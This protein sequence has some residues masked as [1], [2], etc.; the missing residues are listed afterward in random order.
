[1]AL[2]P[3]L[4]E[5][6]LSEEERVNHL[7][8]F[9]QGI[10]EQLESSADQK[11]SVTGAA[12]EHGR[13]RY[14]QGYSIPLM[15]EDARLLQDAIYELIQD[16]LLTLD[17]SRLISDLRR[18]DDTVDIELKEAIQAYIAEEKSA[19]TGKKKREPSRVAKAAARKK[20]AG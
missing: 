8:A 7:P 4:A 2:H 15:I 16:N 3:E 18:M 11:A 6:K 13:M 9:L 5:L 20:V 1:M 17:L 10:A 14:R 19:A 12:A